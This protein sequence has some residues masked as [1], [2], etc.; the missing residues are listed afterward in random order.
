MNELC[1]Y[2]GHSRSFHNYSTGLGPCDYNKTC[3]C[4]EFLNV[5]RIVES[6]A[7]LEVGQVIASFST[8]EGSEELVR[9]GRVVG[10]TKDN[11]EVDNEAGEVK[12]IGFHSQNTIFILAVPP[13]DPSE[14]AWEEWNGYEAGGDG[15]KLS[16]THHAAF[17]AGYKA[18]DQVEST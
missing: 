8:M 10:F 7:D 6:M 16:M 14:K 5:P 13:I 9:A 3:D 4:G 15:I 18:R 11:V 17:M 12:R 1:D 2:C